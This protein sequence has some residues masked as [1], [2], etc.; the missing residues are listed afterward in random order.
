MIK[1]PLISMETKGPPRRTRLG[2]IPVTAHGAIAVVRMVWLVG[3]CG[4]C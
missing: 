1:C 3:V 4:G 2:L